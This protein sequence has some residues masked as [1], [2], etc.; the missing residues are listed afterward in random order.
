MRRYEIEA[1]DRGYQE[2]EP[3]EREVEEREYIG[4][5]VAKDSK[6]LKVQDVTS[7]NKSITGSIERRRIA[8]ARAE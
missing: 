6:R 4:P 8:A 7:I 2:S 5:T 3:V 1:D